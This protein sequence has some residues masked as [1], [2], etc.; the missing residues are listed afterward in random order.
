MNRNYQNIEKGFERSAFIVWFFL[1]LCFIPLPS[2]R[3]YLLSIG[4]YVVDSSTFIVTIA[5]FVLNY[6]NNTLVSWVEK[7]PRISAANISVKAYTPKA[8]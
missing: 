8:R 4:V 1:A 7:L 5:A 2:L 3:N 6:V